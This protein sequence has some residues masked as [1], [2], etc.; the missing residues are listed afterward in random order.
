MRVFT[1]LTACVCN[2]HTR[3]VFHAVRFSVLNTFQPFGY[4]IFHHLVGLLPHAF[5]VNARLCVRSYHSFVGSRFY[6]LCA[7]FFWCLSQKSD[8]ASSKDF[9]KT[10]T[11]DS[12]AEV[13]KSFI[14]DN[15]TVLVSI[16]G[17]DTR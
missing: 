5:A 1:Y 4:L 16:S 14:G 9:K 10:K 13:L 3:F 12:V 17:S 2:A 7:C 15:E 11:R 8:G 6:R